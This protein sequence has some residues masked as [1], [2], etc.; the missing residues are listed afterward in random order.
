M[1]MRFLNQVTPS[2]IFPQ[3]GGALETGNEKRRENTCA[4]GH[5]SPLPL[6]LEESYSSCQHTT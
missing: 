5:K 3:K 1:V 6:Q 4:L 2:L